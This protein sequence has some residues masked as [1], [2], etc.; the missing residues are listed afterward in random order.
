MIER[1]EVIR[2]ALDLLPIRL[3]RK[4]KSEGDLMTSRV[5]HRV[6][7]LVNRLL[8]RVQNDL[9]ILVLLRP[10]H[11]DWIVVGAVSYMVDELLGTESSFRRLFTQILQ[12]RYERACERLVSRRRCGVHRCAKEFVASF[13]APAS[14]EHTCVATVV[15]LES[16]MTAFEPNL[17]IKDGYRS[18]LGESQTVLCLIP[19]YLIDALHFIQFPTRS[20][21]LF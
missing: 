17:P 14:D 5:L 19:Q 20:S 10:V 9:S 1:V 8:D 13:A 15:L 3:S 18:T 6:D 12:G 21:V 11:E 4:V 7:H 2:Q 16:C